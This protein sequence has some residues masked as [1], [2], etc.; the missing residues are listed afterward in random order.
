[1]QSHRNNFLD[2]FDH[3]SAPDLEHQFHS[4]H[5]EATVVSRR[6]TYVGSTQISV[7]SAYLN[8]IY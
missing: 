2:I 8:D 3:A 4:S 6:K 7:I 1:M 5:W